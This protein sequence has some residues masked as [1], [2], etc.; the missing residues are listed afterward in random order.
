MPIDPLTGALVGGGL[1][2]IGGLIGGNDEPSFPYSLTGERRRGAYGDVPFPLSMDAFMAEY[3]KALDTRRFTK[4]GK[5][6]NARGI[7]KGLRKPFRYWAAEAHRAGYS[8]DQLREAVEKYGGGVEGGRTRAIN[9]AESFA[10][11]YQNQYGDIA[12]AQ[13]EDRQSQF[14]TERAGINDRLAEYEKKIRSDSQQAINSAGSFLTSALDANQQDYNDQIRFGS[15]EIDRAMSRAGFIGGRQ[16]RN[17]VGYQSEGMMRANALGGLMR[18]NTAARTAAENQRQEAFGTRNRLLSDRYA[19]AQQ[20]Q[21]NLMN[22]ALATSEI[23]RGQ[24]LYGQET[25]QQALYNFY[26]QPSALYAS[27]IT[28]NSVATG[29]YTSTPGAAQNIG[30]V[31]GGLGGQ[32]AGY[33]IRGLLGGNQQQNSQLPPWAVYGGTGNGVPG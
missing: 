31:L 16:N 30:A 3:E 29:P 25:A 13:A 2:A 15:A 5:E 20:D 19:R 8:P 10:D 7:F 33:G 23:G 6:R 11:F 21:M 14:D 17:T 4:K 32:L 1:S 28:K 26:A 27:P 18:A 12:G 22:Q 24:Q 9:S